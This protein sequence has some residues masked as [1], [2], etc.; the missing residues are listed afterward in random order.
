MRAIIYGVLWTAIAMSCAHAGDIVGNG[1]A[2]CGSW[3]EHQGDRYFA[4]IDHAWLAGYLSGY[5]GYRN[6]KIDMPIQQLGMN[7]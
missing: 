1:T 5:F 3:T 2:S 4:F 7:G 6:D